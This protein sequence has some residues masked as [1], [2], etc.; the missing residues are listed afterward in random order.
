[1]RGVGK[2]RVSEAVTLKQTIDINLSSGWKWYLFV[3]TSAQDAWSADT[4]E[5]SIAQTI[6]ITGSSI[7]LT[8]L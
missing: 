4:I 1:M 2:K 8:G 3:Q 7:F 6:H 5:C